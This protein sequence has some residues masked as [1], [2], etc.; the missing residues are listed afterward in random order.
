MPEKSDYHFTL[1][2]RARF[3]VRAFCFRRSNT[4][5]G[6]RRV[7]AC[8]DS[9]GAAKLAGMATIR[10]RRFAAAAV[11]VLFLLLAVVLSSGAA[12]IAAAAPTNAPDLSPFPP[13]LESYHDADMTGVWQVLLN[14]IH[15]EPFN[16][17]ATL[18]FLAA[19]VHTFLTHKFIRWANVLEE[20][21]EQP[22]QADAPHTG[23]CPASMPA[24]VLHFFGEVEVVF[25]IWVIPLFLLMMWRVG[26]QPTL[27]YLNQ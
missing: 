27:D 22:W 14:R 9:L 1:G 4:R 7:R 23:P 6:W 11:T 21:H 20:Q 26:R 2:F 3:Q 12:D 16:L 10:Y 5:A 19:V 13:H 25:G 24:R 15:Q 17:W 8:T 18:I